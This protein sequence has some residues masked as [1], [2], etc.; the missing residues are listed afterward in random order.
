M[1]RA[2]MAVDAGLRS[3]MLGVFNKMALGLLVSGALAWFVGNTPAVA[4][5]IFGTPLRWVVTFAPLAILL[6]VPMA[7]RNPSPAGTSLVYWSLVSIIGVSLG[8]IFLAYTNASIATTFFATAAA[9]GGL[10]L[11]GYTTKKDLT[12]FGSFLIMGLIGLMVASIV[13][14]FL[15]SSGLAFAISAIGVLVFSG[16]TAFDT[17]RLKYTYYE[18]GGDARAMSVATNFG[19]LSMYLNFVNLFQMLLSFFGQRE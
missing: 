18:L 9:Y 10:A 2:D 6:I 7:M 13:N 11:W 19:A 4:Q 3:F 17:Q 1:G 12:G 15:K 16:L 14:I 8:Y 5:L